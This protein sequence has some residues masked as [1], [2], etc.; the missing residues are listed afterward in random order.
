[1]SGSRSKY[2]EEA[3]ARRRNTIR[4]VLL[5]IGLG[6]AVLLV[7][8]AGRFAYGKSK[9]PNYR[10]ADLFRFSKTSEGTLPT[11]PTLPVNE[12]ASLVSSSPEEAMSTEP[13][14]DPSSSEEA[15]LPPETSSEEAET[16]ESDTAETP[17]E[18]TA[19][20]TAEL[21]EAGD[22]SEETSPLETDDTEPAG[23]N[24]ET[25]PSDETGSEEET[26]SAEETE[27]SSETEPQTEPVVVSDV[28]DV[29]YHLVRSSMEESDL[30]SC[31]QLIVVQSN[32]TQCT[33]YFFDK[34]DD[35]WKISEAIPSAPGIVGR[36][37]VTTTKAEGDGCTPA[38]YYAIGPC[39]GED[40]TS[41]TAME[42]HQIIN[43]DFWVDDPAS[44]YYNQFVRTTDS[45]VYPDWRSGEDLYSL[46]RY[47]KYMAVVRYNMDPVVSGAGSAIFLHCQGGDTTTSGCVS[48]KEAT[49]FAIFRWL[50]PSADPHILIY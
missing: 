47:Y 45:H 36:S 8:F 7:I 42:Y 3:V 44:L 26:S 20:E 32:G 17:D 34:T 2:S 25:D 15:T 30:G 6:F 5:G 38:G 10:L 22:T 13:E 12:I 16:P 1:M 23:S 31:R 41:V 14:Q 46:L 39:Y 43:G 35:G 48:T 28:S 33:L 19:S 21:T 37:G 4:N 11:L 27:S 18:P 24:E 40:A 49:M 9:N 29:N 50:K